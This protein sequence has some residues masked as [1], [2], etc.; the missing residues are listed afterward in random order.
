MTRL[1]RP[2][3][4]LAAGLLFLLGS[5]YCVVSAVSGDRSM[6]CVALPASPAPAAASHCHGGTAGAPATG[7]HAPTRPA[8]HP[9][10]LDLLASAAPHVGPGGV[11][12]FHLAVLIPESQ[13]A[14]LSAVV[15]WLGHPT[16]RDHPPPGDDV[17]SLTSPR[18]P[19]LA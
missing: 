12:A 1:H 3:P 10:C 14:A 11:A 2:L 8:A 7:S 6:A 9:C 17:A 19:P 4:T 15:S 5:N 16:S 18:A 13:G